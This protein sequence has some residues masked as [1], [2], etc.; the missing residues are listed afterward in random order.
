V[1]D[2]T[3]YPVFPWIIADYQSSALGMRAPS[4]PDRRTSCELSLFTPTFFPTQ[5]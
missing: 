4:P 3:Q 2:I 5:T 1:N